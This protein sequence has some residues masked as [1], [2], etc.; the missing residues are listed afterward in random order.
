MASFAKETELCDTFMKAVPKEWTVY[1]ETG[2]FDILLVR[3]ED[4]FQIGIEAKLKLNA[5]V[6]TQI[7][8]RIGTHYTCDEGPDCRAIL[9]PHGVNAELGGVCELLGLEVVRVYHSSEQEK[10]FDKFSPHLPTISD[11]AYWCQRNWFEFCPEKRV[12][13][14]DYVPDTIAGD[15]SPVI[16]TA[17]KI[18]AMKL[19][20]VL[21]KTGFLTRQDFKALEVSMSRWIQYGLTSWLIP[22]KIKGQWVRGTNFPDFV[23]QHPVNYHQI[24]AD[25]EEWNPRKVEDGLFAQ[26]KG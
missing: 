1:A 6:I 3:N 11:G 25:Y 22:G 19:A 14:P 15:K 20:I 13:L 2:G 26:P 17:W 12:K 5:K 4:G 21:E 23:K 10:W 18:A 8:E 7:A 16:L 24:A 9:V